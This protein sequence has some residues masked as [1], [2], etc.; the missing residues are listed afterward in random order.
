MINLLPPDMRVELRAAKANTTLRKYLFTALAASASL[1]MIFGGALYINQVY[2]EDYKRQLADSEQKLA[3]L[4]DLRQRVKVYNESLAQAKDI[5]GKEIRLSNLIRNLSGTLPPGAVLNTVSFNVGSL[6][7]P[8]SITAQLDSFEKAAVLK[9]NFEDS[10]LF[11]TVVL[12]QVNGVGATSDPGVEGEEPANIYPFTAAL[13]VSLSPEA[14]KMAKTGAP[15]T[16]G[17]RP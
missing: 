17:E 15:L 16:E 9:R 2:Y 3:S 6:D 4:Q 11:T 14:S 5:F 7:Q 1:L 12:T 10:G 8:L 13:E